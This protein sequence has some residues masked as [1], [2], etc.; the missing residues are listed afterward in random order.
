MYFDGVTNTDHTVVYFNGT[1]AETK[2]WLENEVKDI[3]NA[4]MIVWD[5]KTLRGFSPREY[6][7]RSA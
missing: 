6:L 4:K 1:P 5:G 2:E 7:N 3:D